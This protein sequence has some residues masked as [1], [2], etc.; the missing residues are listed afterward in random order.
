MYLHVAY[1]CTHN[2]LEVLCVSQ[3]TLEF[4]YRLKIKINYKYF[5][6][7]LTIL[8]FI[9]KLSLSY[10]FDILKYFMIYSVITI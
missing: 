9:L 7:F 8:Y 1:K 5:M 2:T 3:N 10:S 4:T 6:C